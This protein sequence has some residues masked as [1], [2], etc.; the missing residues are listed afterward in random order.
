MGGF[1]RPIRAPDP[2]PGSAAVPGRPFAMATRKA[3]EDA[4]APIAALWTG[5]TAARPL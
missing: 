2:P 4:R 5:G 3:G 1:G